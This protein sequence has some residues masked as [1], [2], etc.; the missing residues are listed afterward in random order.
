MS[1]RRYQDVYP[2]KPTITSGDLARRAA[3]ELL[4]LEY[5][6]AEPGEMPTEIFEQ[7]HVLLNLKKEPHRVEN[8]RNGEHRDF[9]F[10]Q[11]EV[12]VT[13]AGVSSGWKWHAPSRVIVITLEPEK[14][15]RF[16]KYELGIVLG[17]E[18]LLDEPQFEDPGLVQ[19]GWDLCNALQA[20][21]G[22]AVIYESLS[23][24][25]LVKLLERYGRQQNE[26][27]AFSESFTVKHYQRVLNFVANNYGRSITVEDMAKQTAISPF[28][29]S[30]LFKRTIGESPYQF[31]TA[32]RVEK[33]KEALSSDAEVPLIDIA[34]SCGFADQAHFS[35]TFKKSTGKT[36]KAWR[37]GE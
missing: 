15:E 5:F 26:E 33:A 31:L 14:L 29:F 30:R 17:Q 19:A 10:R 3:A 34:L 22:S 36:P 4:T 37:T 2:S 23:R 35:R 13:P 20:E 18:Q 8:W 9:I 1:A 16:A 12:V 27:L 25:F 28:H 21:F 7:H 24:I 32:Y 6:E 11:N